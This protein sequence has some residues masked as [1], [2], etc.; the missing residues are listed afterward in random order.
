MKTVVLRY[1]E[2]THKTTGLITARFQYLRQSDTG[3]RKLV[4]DSAVQGAQ[5]MIVGIESGQDG[6]VR[7]RSNS[8]LSDGII[9]N[10]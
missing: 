2:S 7:Y 10:Y 9:E 5:F 6:C 4:A 8:R 3:F 1:R